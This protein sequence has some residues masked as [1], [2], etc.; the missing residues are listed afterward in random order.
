MVPVLV[1]LA[2]VA[3]L[4]DQRPQLQRPVPGQ[5]PGES[6][7]PTRQGL[8]HL[9]F[10]HQRRLDV[11]P[12]VGL[13]GRRSGYPLPVP[14]LDVC[15]LARCRVAQRLHLPCLGALVSEHLRRIHPP[16][17]LPFRHRQVHPID[18]TLAVP[19]IPLH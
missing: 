11:I 19:R 9:A 15:N 3:T 12:R 4:V 2:A 13:E 10:L 5:L 7:A 6:C 16:E 8:L 14:S 18:H 1:I 17:R